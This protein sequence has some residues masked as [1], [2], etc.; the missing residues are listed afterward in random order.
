M[1]TKNVVIIVVVWMTCGLTMGSLGQE[2]IKMVIKKCEKSGD[3]VDAEIIRN[4]ERESNVKTSNP[5]RLKKPS[6]IVNLTLR[7][8]PS[9]EKELVDAFRKDQAKAISEVEQVK[10]GK[11]LH[12]LYQ[13]EDS[14]YSFRIEGNAIKIQATEGVVVP[15][16]FGIS[17]DE[18]LRYSNGETLRKLMM[19]KEYNE[20]KK[21]E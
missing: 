15:G 19:E 9:L 21:K 4:K 14:Q 13:F 6:S 17:L 1:K 7:N 12:M 11:I 16:F 3:L 8:S 2:N 5:E 20:L 18:L 10:E